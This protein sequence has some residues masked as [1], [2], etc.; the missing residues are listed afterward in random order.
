MRERDNDIRLN[1]LFLGI[2]Q[3]KGIRLS[4]AAFCSLPV[5]LRQKARRL[6]GKITDRRREFGNGIKTHLPSS[7]ACGKSKA[8]HYVVV[9]VEN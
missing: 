4:T 5:L 7:C 1:Q 8:S 2:I 9:N 6:F 3:N